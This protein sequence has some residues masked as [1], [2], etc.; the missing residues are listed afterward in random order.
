VEGDVKENR[1]PKLRTLTVPELEVKLTQM[2]E[3]VF[4]LRFR[5]SVQ[6]LD[7]PLKLR[8]TRRDIA[9]IET[10]LQEHRKGIR[11]VAAQSNA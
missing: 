2:R 9:R 4:N 11:S 7:D 3:E 10:I 5:N 8:G 6:Q 1:A